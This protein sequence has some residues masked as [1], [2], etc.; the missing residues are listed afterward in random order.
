V[1]YLPRALLQDDRWGLI[2]SVLAHELAHVARWDDLLL[3]IQLLVS[4]LYFFNPVAWVCARRM[5]DES[6]RICDGMVLGSG[7]ISAKTYGQSILAVLQLGVTTE[8]NLIPALVSTKERLEMRLKS[9]KKGSSLRRANVL[10]SL[11]AALA[12]GLVL[13]PMSTGSMKPENA[14]IA[15]AVAPARPQ[16]AVLANPMPGSRVS[17]AW[18]RRTNPYTGEEA[19]HRGVDLVNKPGSP[20]HAAADGVVEVA[21]ADYAGG[22]NHGTVIIIDHGGGLKTF[23]SHLDMLA[24]EVGDRVSRGGRIGTQGST[25]KVTGPHLHFEVWVDGEYV[26]PARFVA[27]WPVTRESLYRLLE[28][29]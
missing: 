3:E 21:T 28:R 24:V 27:D 7:G 26:D 6:E 23:Y 17:S 11:P 14:E 10:Y 20:V 2:E 22:E 12:F 4:V 19:H 18:G 9:I 25:G 13:L 16:D 8:P 29:S 5:R 15:D 1:V